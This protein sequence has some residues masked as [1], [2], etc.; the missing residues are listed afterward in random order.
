MTFSPVKTAAFAA[1]AT[2]FGAVGALADGHLTKINYGYLPVPTAPLFA[3][4]AHGLFEKHGLDVELIKFTSGPAEFQ[5]L[6]AGSIDLAQGALA[7]FYMASSR[8]LAANWVYSFGDAASIEGF[9][10]GDRDDRV[11][12]G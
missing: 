6:Q 9:V 4:E 7:A 11:A 8:G 5:S 3:A 1:V 12:R 10:L 2:V